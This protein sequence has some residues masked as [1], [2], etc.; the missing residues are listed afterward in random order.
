MVTGL[1][2]IA[3]FGRQISNSFQRMNENSQQVSFH[4]VLPS[5][6]SHEIFSQ[7][8]AGKF[9]TMLPKEIQLDQKFH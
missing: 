9:T 8:Q 2:L 5:I 7:N 4:L 3:G 6:S 1:I